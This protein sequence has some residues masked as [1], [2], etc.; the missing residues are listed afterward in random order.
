MAAPSICRV[1]NFRDSATLEFDKAPCIPHPSTIDTFN[2]LRDADR[3]SS[4]RCTFL[5]KNF[6]I[7][8]HL[9]L[10]IALGIGDVTSRSVA[11][12]IFMPWRV[13]CVSSLMALARSFWRVPDVRFLTLRHSTKLC[14]AHRCSSPRSTNSHTHLGHHARRTSFYEA[15]HLLPGQC[16]KEIGHATLLRTAKGATSALA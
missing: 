2:A 14:L 6:K 9:F 8:C 7:N 11:N 1:S 3:S 5:C 12:T 4:P 13:S 15:A 16:A 10:C